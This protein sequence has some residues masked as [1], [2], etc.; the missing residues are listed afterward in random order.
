MVCT[1][2]VMVVNGDEWDGTSRPMIDGVVSPGGGGGCY[3][4]RG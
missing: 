3:S 2:V 4:K 1:G